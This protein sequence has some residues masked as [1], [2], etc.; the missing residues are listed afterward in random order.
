MMQIRGILGDADA[1][2]ARHLPESRPESE[3][4]IRKARDQALELITRYA[5]ELAREAA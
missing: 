4:E 1:V 2:L 3:G 5:G